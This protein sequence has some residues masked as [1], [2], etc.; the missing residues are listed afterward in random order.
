MAPARYAPLPHF[1]QPSA[2]AEREIREAFELDKD[3]EDATEETHLTRGYEPAPIA[4]PHHAS[5]PAATTPGT[6]DFER[7]Y[8]Y[9]Y[10]PPGSPPDQSKAV[11]NNIGNS[12]G[13]LPGTPSRP[14]PHGGSPQR[15]LFRRVAGALL[16]QHYQRVPAEPTASRPVGGGMDNDG[17]FANVMAKPGRAVAVQGENGDVFMVPEEVQSNAPPVSP[18]P[19]MRYHSCAERCGFTS[20]SHTA[21][22]RRMPCRPTGRRQYMHHRASTL[23]PT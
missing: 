4:A 17:V 20:R 19:A 7:E 16:P 14:D 10:P 6:Y 15:S 3:D 11:P 1:P 13:V 5:A 8:D 21:R 18:T 22:R 2:D 12:N 9:D 23:M